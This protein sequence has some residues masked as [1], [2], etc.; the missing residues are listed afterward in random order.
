MCTHGGPWDKPKT[1]SEPGKRDDW[2]EETREKCSTRCCCSVVS[3]SVT[4]G[5]AAR[6]AFVSHYFPELAQTHVHGVSDATQPAQPLSPPSPPACNLSSDSDYHKG[7]ARSPLV[8]VSTRSL[9][10]PNR[11]FTRF[12]ALSLSMEIHF[13][14]AGG[15][16]P[17]PRPLAPGALAAGVRGSRRCSLSSVSGQE[18]KTSPKPPQAGA[19]RDHRLQP[20]LGGAQGKRPSLY[21]TTCKCASAW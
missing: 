14:T 1:D 19:T 5:T 15:P 21:L 16:G 4:P 9:F 7:I 17:C 6:R 2:P 12:T 8:C 3:D 11:H 13:Y 10:P 18:L 20:R